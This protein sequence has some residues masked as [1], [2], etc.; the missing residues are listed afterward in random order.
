MNELKLYRVTA[1]KVLDNTCR[2]PLDITVMS[3]TRDGAVRSACLNA[4]Y[5]SVTHAAISADM[6][7]FD[8]M[9]VVQ[10]TEVED[11]SHIVPAPFTEAAVDE[12]LEHVARAM[13][14]LPSCVACAVQYWLTTERLKR[15]HG[16][17][18]DD[19]DVSWVPGL[20]KAFE[21]HINLIIDRPAH[22][23][24]GALEVTMTNGARVRFN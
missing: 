7:Y 12:A 20:I 1:V 5:S 13:E 9:K 19:I 6:D 21:R 8:L 10:V 24:P 11:V 18:T 2:L 14:T 22:A 15:R 4:G 16:G 23:E 17:V 3:D